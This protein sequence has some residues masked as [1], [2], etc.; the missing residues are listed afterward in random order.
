MS[1]FVLRHR[2]Q[3][4]GD[5]GGGGG[6]EGMETKIPR[7]AH[8][9][10]VGRHKTPLAQSARIGF[11][12][13]KAHTTLDNAPRRC[14]HPICRRIPWQ[15]ASSKL[16]RLSSKS[17]RRLEPPTALPPPALWPRRH[18]SH[19]PSRQTSTHVDTQR[20]TVQ[21]L[22]RTPYRAVQQEHA[23]RIYRL[24]YS[25]ALHHQRPRFFRERWAGFL[26]HG[27]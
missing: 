1:P 2:G 18:R 23:P 5:G 7:A 17:P 10:A 16:K 19:I 12:G 27:L 26:A 15:T 8:V 21:N 25:C 6:G 20:R 11:Q 24:P 3:G 4:D 14:I 13:Q 9:Y 22:S